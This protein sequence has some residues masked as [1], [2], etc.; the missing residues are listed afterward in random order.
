MKGDARK[1]RR[2][3][4]HNHVLIRETT[5]KLNIA[6]LHVMTNPELPNGVMIVSPEE[7]ERLANMVA[8]ATA[9]AK[10]KEAQNDTA[11]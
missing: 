8:E 2:K 10:I 5:H 3:F 9:N 11:E 4:E 6:G 1:A 7:G